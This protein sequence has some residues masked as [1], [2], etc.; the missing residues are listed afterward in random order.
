MLRSF[1]GQQAKSGVVVMT[2]MPKENYTPALYC[3]INRPG[4]KLLIQQ[5]SLPKMLRHLSRRLN[6]NGF[7]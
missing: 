5:I 6:I 4:K 2:L 1:K 7:N 3:S